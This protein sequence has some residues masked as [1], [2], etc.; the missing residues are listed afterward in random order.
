MCSIHMPITKS[1]EKALRGSDKKRVSNLRRTRAFKDLEKQIQK[2]IK[3]GKTK[4]AEALLPKL[5]KTLD[6]ASKKNTIKKGTADRKKS[7]L[8]ALIKKSK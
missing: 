1:A 5:Y 2:L 7:R 3:A 8:S 4:E 6:K